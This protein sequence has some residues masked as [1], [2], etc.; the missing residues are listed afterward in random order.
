M[1]M[2]AKHQPKRKHHLVTS[3]VVVTE[4]SRSHSSQALDSPMKD[5]TLLVFNGQRSAA[6]LWVVSQ[7]LHSL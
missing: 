6:M 5:R 3:K 7:S 2:E 4:V 1:E